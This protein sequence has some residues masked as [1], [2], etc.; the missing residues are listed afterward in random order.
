MFST[1]EDSQSAVSFHCRDA[2]EVED[3]YLED[4][5][6][7]VEMKRLIHSLHSRSNQGRE[8]VLVLTCISEDATAH[9]SV[10]ITGEDA[11]SIMKNS[12]VD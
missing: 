11:V 6:V 2:V 8:R 9:S 3:E 4:G 7:E 10:A 1:L 5:T 12:G